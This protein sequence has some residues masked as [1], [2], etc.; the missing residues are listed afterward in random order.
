M[1]SK[2]ALVLFAAVVALA[3]ADD[4][5][6]GHVS[7]YARELDDCLFTCTEKYGKNG[8]KKTYPPKEN[9]CKLSCEEAF[10]AEYGSYGFYPEKQNEC[11][12]RCDEIYGGSYPQKNPECR[13]RCGELYGY[14]H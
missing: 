11:R 14:R 4:Y 13:Q 8:Y 1:N 6:E 9:E 5:P 12:Q 2:I 7:G 10:S 3:V